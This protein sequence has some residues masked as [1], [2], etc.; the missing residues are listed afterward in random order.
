M[1]YGIP[2]I[3]SKTAKFLVSLALMA[4]LIILLYFIGYQVF[5]L[6]IKAKNYPSLEL[7][8]DIV[9][10]VVLV[11]AYRLIMFYL[12][13]HHASLRYIVEISILAPAIEIIFSLDNKGLLENIVL[14]AFGLA[15]LLIY[16]IFYEKLM[17]YEKTG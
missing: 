2:Q 14:G 17:L 4:T 6:F 12:E 15:N 5:L 16:L 10:I 13:T 3:I 1:K 7:L 11:K 9:F 8:H